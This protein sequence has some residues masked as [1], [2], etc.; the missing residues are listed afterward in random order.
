MLG[1][2]RRAPSDFTEELQAHLQLEVDRLRAEGLS[3]EDAYRQARRALGNLGIAKERFYESSRPLWL[4]HL[5]QDIRHTFRRLRKAPA[6]AIT[7]VLTL[8][9]G[10][11]ATSSIFTLVHAVLLKSLAVANPQDL[12]RLGKETHCC[13][14]EGY[15]QD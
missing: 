8:A 4:D 10:I 2:R 15:N 9:L 14:W 12:Y 13:V 11:G 6:F 7:T 1:R 5:T 3:E